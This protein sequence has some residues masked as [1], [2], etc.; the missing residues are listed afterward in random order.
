M[1]TGWTGESTQ[2]NEISS[3]CGGNEAICPLVNRLITGVQ[4]GV[5]DPL[6]THRQLLV[7]DQKMASEA[8]WKPFLR[9]SLRMD[10]SDLCAHQLLESQCKTTLSSVTSDSQDS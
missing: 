1:R 6:C 7:P 2:S 4:A 5:E 3:A 8:Q 9:L 10:P